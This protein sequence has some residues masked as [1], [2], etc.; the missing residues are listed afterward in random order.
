MPAVVS[1]PYIPNPNINNV[2][3]EAYSPK[4][5][6]PFLFQIV[7]PG[8]N[9]PL[10]PTLLAMHVNPESLEE[11]MAA[12]KTVVPTKGG[13]VEFRWPNELTSVSGGNTTG[14]F[15]SPSSGLTAGSAGAQIGGKSSGRQGTMAW[16]RQ[17]DLLDLFHNNGMVFDGN[18][19]P[20]IRGRVM[21]IYD[22]GIFLG[23]FTTFDVNEDETHSYSFHIDWS[24][25]IEK[26]IYRFPSV[27]G[28]SSVAMPVPAP[29]FPGTA[30]AIPGSLGA[31]AQTNPSNQQASAPTPASTAPTNSFSS[32]NPASPNFN[33][34][35]IIP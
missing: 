8:T 31:M 3:P 24:F 4:R 34:A 35:S 16:E 30:Q 19:A 28:S 26:T 11:R 9:Q 29:L 12:S 20:A 23:F 33:A 17:E 27:V 13:W 22:R 15:Y 7:S 5:G 21:M 1:L 6:K 18:G 14:A 32:N 25:T 10:Y 2:D